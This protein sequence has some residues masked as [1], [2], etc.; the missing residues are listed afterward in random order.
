M[1]MENIRNEKENILKLITMTKQNVKTDKMN[2][3]KYNDSRF[4]TLKNLNKVNI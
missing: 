2:I 1:L 3:F 4:I